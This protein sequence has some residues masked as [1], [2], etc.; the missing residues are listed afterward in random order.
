MSVTEDRKYLDPNVNRFRA[1]SRNYVCWNGLDLEL[2]HDCVLPR[3]HLVEKLR[4]KLDQNRFVMF[5]SMSDACS[6]VQP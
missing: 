4:A 5:C 6:Q 1:G 2:E 3:N